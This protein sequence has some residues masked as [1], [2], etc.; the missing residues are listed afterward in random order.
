MA[1]QSEGNKF[2]FGCNYGPQTET[3]HESIDFSDLC[4]FRN[5]FRRLLHPDEE[6][7]NSETW[8]T[9]VLQHCPIWRYTDTL[10]IPCS[11]GEIMSDC[12]ARLIIGTPTRFRLH[13]FSWMI[14][15]YRMTH[16]CSC[17]YIYTI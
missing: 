11:M 10:E 1:L 13:L 8:Y 15:P 14:E 12:R 2:L 16:I 6:V 4:I 3:V 7:V 9:Q 17:R 5:V